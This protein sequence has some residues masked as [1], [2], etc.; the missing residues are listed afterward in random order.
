VIEVIFEQGLLQHEV[1]HSS[2]VAELRNTID[3]LREILES[4][5]GLS[6][7]LRKWNSPIEKVSDQER[8]KFMEY[9]EKIAD[10]TIELEWSFVSGFEQQPSTMRN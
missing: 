8:K 4:N 5:D 7:V 3:E 1:N 9:I 2:T 6:E 10:K